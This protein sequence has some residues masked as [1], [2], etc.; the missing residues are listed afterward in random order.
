MVLW[1]NDTFALQ[2]W[3]W[4]CHQL[5]YWDPLLQTGESS[6]DQCAL[7]WAGGSGEGWSPRDFAAWALGTGV[8][9]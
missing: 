1:L 6:V 3:G 8:Q 4:R 5:E 9:L 2:C 7:S